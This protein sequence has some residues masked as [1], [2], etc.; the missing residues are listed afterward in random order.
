MKAVEIKK[1]YSATGMFKISR[2]SNMTFPHGNLPEL[3][4]YD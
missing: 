2:N 3:G 1:W 4:T